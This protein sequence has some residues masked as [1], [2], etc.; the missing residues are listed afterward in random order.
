MTNLLLIVPGTQLN[1]WQHSA[2]ENPEQGIQANVNGQFFTA[3]GLFWMVRKMRVRRGTDYGHSV[4]H[5]A[6]AV[7][8]AL[9]IQV[10]QERY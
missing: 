8:T 7:R 1:T 10:E 4:T 9:S 3:N 6:D 2:A 5:A